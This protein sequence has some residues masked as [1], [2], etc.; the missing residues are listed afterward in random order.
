MSQQLLAN[1]HNRLRDSRLSLVCPSGGLG[2]VAD[3]TKKK[4][5]V[6]YEPRSAHERAVNKPQTAVTN[7]CLNCIPFMNL[8]FRML[9]RT[10]SEVIQYYSVTDKF[11]FK[12][13]TVRTGN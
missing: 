12:N 8:T 3:K 2:L 10:S 13:T 9:Q 7:I 6:D 5:R 4:P 11:K 1:K